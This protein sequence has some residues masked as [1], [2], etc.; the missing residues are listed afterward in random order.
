MSLSI[1]LFYLYL[2]WTKIT[3]TEIKM[4]KNYSII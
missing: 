2:T 1:N 3:K 4:N